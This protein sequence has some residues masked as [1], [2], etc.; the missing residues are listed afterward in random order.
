MRALIALKKYVLSV[1][2][3]WFNINNTSKSF[4]DYNHNLCS[5]NALL[6]VVFFLI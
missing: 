2:E 1:I 6:K 3:I 4:L 5:Q